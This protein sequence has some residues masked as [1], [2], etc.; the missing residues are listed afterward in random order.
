MSRESVR[1]AINLSLAKTRG[2]VIV[3][4]IKRM[5]KYARCRGYGR[6]RVFSPANSVNLAACEMP[7]GNG[8][9]ANTL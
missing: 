4:T 3:S 6:R 7:D 8:L 1:V 9:S 2:S 5:P